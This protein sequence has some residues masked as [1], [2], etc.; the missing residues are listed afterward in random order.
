MF[1]INERDNNVYMM[2][3]GPAGKRVYREIE[4][5][6]AALEAFHKA[7]GLEMA[8][9]AREVTG[10][11][12]HRA[13][14]L[15]QL[16]TEGVGK[17]FAVDVKARLTQATLMIAAQQLQRFP[18][19]GLIVTDYVNPIMAERLRAM[20]MPFLDAAGNAYIN[21]PPVYVYI[22][23]NKPVETPQRKGHTRAFQPTGL[24]VLFAFLCHPGLENAPYREIAKAADVALGT[25]GWVITDLKELGYLVDM[26]KRGRKLTNK[27][28]LI[29]RW[30]MAYPEQLRPKLLLGRYKAAD[31]DWWRNTS[32][33][34]AQAYWGG[35]VAAAMLTRYLKP[36]QETLYTRKMRNDF[37]LNNKLKKDPNGDVEILEAFWQAEFDWPYP[38]LAPPLLIYA[39]LLAT[40]DA[41]NIETARMIYEQQ[42]A[43]PVRED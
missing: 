33:Q 7:T 42:L 11:S 18:Q 30:V 34:G 28:K 35:E 21:E 27:E 15:L 24:K 43:G 13:D 5:L 16:N 23:G 8:V 25:V 17:Q 29:E 2:L 26:G 40:G 12:T 4:L 6:Q 32:I 14:A 36:E 22:K 19:K 20:D 41:R 10:D 3:G 9:A 31:P 1:T 37:L 38:E 39:D